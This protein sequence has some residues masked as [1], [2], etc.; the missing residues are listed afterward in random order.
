[1][2]KFLKNFCIELDC[3]DWLENED[4]KHET[5]Q[6]LFEAFNNQKPFKG[7]WLNACLAGKEYIKD[8]YVNYD[9]F[10]P[11]FSKN[12]LPFQ[13]ESKGDEKVVKFNPEIH[14]VRKKAEDVKDF[15]NEGPG[16]DAAA[17]SF[18]L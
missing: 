1:M 7:K 4:G 17:N 9:L 12:G 13:N 5:I 11:K 10:F 16:D 15:G 8:N 14:I 3:L 2:L 6:S 18:K